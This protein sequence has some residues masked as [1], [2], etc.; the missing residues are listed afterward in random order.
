MARKHG[1]ARAPLKRAIREA[2][3]ADRAMKAAI[4]PIAD[5]LAPTFAA[6]QPAARFL[7]AMAPL[8]D[9]LAKAGMLPTKPTTKRGLFLLDPA[10]QATV[11]D[12]AAERFDLPPG[13]WRDLEICRW[14]ALALELERRESKAHASARRILDRPR[15]EVL[16][17]RGA[18]RG[19]RKKNKTP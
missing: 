18:P 17:K 4:Q 19:P 15:G 13:A 9:G 1:E 8:V 2:H 12:A 3:K 6:K 5:K 7:R 11:L 10:F 14:L 16:R